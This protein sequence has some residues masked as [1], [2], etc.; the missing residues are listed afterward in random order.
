MALSN[1]SR[2]WSI[3]GESATYMPKPSTTSSMRRGGTPRA[4]GSSNSS[5]GAVRRQG[6]FSNWLDM[7][8]ISLSTLDVLLV[9]AYL[10]GVVA[11]GVCEKTEIWDE[12]GENVIGT[13]R[14][15]GVLPLVD[16]T[17]GYGLTPQFELSLDVKTLLF[18]TLIGIKTKYYMQDAKETSFFSL[19]G[20]AVK[21]GGGHG[22]IVTS[23]NNVEYGYA[24]G[25]NEFTVGAGAVY[26]ESNILLHVGYK[27]MF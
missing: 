5:S 3:A 13:Q 6:A 10:V 19:T 1:L 27:Y 2:S 24:Y 25:K 8:E 7:N 21:I 4:T 11:L 26:G 16:V 18:G 20:G 23:Y 17:L 14:D 22:P 12:K 15:C 9:L